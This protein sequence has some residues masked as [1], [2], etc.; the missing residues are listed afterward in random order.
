M[1]GRILTVSTLVALA[2]ARAIITNNCPHPIYIWSVPSVGSAH[3]DNLPINSGGRYEEPWRYGS[4]QH[5]G[6]ALKVSPQ[7]NGINMDMDEVNFAYS[8][9]RSD[10]SKVWVDL[11]PIRGKSFDNKIAFHTCHGVH[12][13]SNVHT[14]KCEATDDIE[15]VLCGTTRSSPVKDSVPFNMI[16]ECYDYHDDNGKTDDSDDSDGGYSKPYSPPP[17]SSSVKS[18]D[19]SA[20]PVTK[21]KTMAYQPPQYKTSTASKYTA[22]VYSDPLKYT[23]SKPYV[24][25]PKQTSSKPYSPPSKQTTEQSYPPPPKQTS[26]KAYPPPSK[27]TSG[28]P[29]PPP[30]KQSSEKPYPPPKQTNGKPNPPP[31]PHTTQPYLPPQYT[32]DSKD[33]YS[34]PQRPSYHPHGDRPGSPSKPTGNKYE[35]PRPTPSGGDRWSRSAVVCSKKNG[36]ANCSKSARK[37]HEYCK[38][39]VVYANASSQQR[40]LSHTVAT[41]RTLIMVPLK[42]VMQREAAK[43]QTAAV[44]ATQPSGIAIAQS[45]PG[46][47]LKKCI[48]PF[49]TPVQP[50]VSCDTAVSELKRPA[51]NQWDWTDDENVC[52]PFLRSL[53]RGDRPDVCIAPVC[54]AYKEED[55]SDLEKKYEQRAKN[56]GNDVDY[57]TDDNDCPG[58]WASTTSRKSSI[59]A[60][61][62]MSTK[63][64]ATSLTA[65]NNTLTDAH[66]ASLSARQKKSPGFHLTI[67][68]SFFCEGLSDADCTKKEVERERINKSKGFNV[69]YTH[70][71]RFCGS[72]GPKAQQAADEVRRI[73]G[74]PIGRNIC[75]R[76][77]CRYLDYV[78]DECREFE[79]LVEY[80][81]SEIGGVDIDFTDDEEKPLSVCSFCEPAVK[82]ADCDEVED[83]LTAVFLLRNVDIDDF[84]EDDWDTDDCTKKPRAAHLRDGKPAVCIRQLCKSQVYND[85]ACD[86]LE[87][88]LE[89]AAIKKLHMEIDYTT[90]EDVCG[91]Y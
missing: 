88:E 71:P 87:L 19:Y 30:P 21:S 9:D 54:A 69:D 79:E 50:G 84:D 11:S 32:S 56:G 43:H 20:I 55:C 83:M 51:I 29:Y 10:N 62:A 17:K 82:G 22:A 45:S 14:S 70:D 52:A 39:K 2:Q 80:Y 15:L 27:Q 48:L 24:S 90:D 38:A 33:D 47:E 72:W 40:D 16:S 42:T 35:I 41:P 81:A 34:I 4:S 3:T 26:S 36:H 64:D 53:D 73:Q 13:S 12:K 8:V 57:T 7:S 68:S 67:C 1:A 59:S 76:Q 49:C 86:E 77:T 5:P 60:R 18:I 23:A 74:K 25:P 61:R 37:S 89:A 78:S 66:N 31:P 91:K 28:K 63:Q 44:P 75:S 85:E 46:T 6:V 58:I 65:A